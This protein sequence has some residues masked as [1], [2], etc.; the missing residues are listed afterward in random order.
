MF[1]TFLFQRGLKKV[2]LEIR[3]SFYFMNL[4]LKTME[5]GV[6]CNHKERNP[7]QGKEC[8]KTADTLGTCIRGK[9]HSAGFQLLLLCTHCTLA[10]SS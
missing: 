8:F 2:S 3:N 10:R 5:F 6:H 1:I 9:M 7:V 4:A